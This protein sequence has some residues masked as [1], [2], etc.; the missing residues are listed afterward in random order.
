MTSKR[1]N[2]TSSNASNSGNNTPSE[3]QKESEYNFFGTKC[4]KI[5]SNHLRRHKNTSKM[6]QV[7]YDGESIAENED[8]LILRDFIGYNGSQYICRYHQGNNCPNH[9]E[10]LKSDVRRTIFN[11]VASY[12]FTYRCSTCAKKYNTLTNLSIHL[13]SAHY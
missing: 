2:Y 10:K 4:L 6:Y 13:N 5:D 11:H 3:P 9:A 1:A 12:F 7:Y 8:T